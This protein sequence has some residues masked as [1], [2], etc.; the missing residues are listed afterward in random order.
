MNN[1]NV[2]ILHAVIDKGFNL[3]K[4]FPLSYDNKAGNNMHALYQ[5]VKNLAIQHVQ[6]AINE[7]ISVRQH[8]NYVVEM[9]ENLDRFPTASIYKDGVCE[10]LFFATISRPTPSV[11]KRWIGG[12][13]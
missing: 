3:I 11:R 8:F 13:V 1:N 7:D 6:L 12:I 4:T 10:E 5:S 2:N 9:E